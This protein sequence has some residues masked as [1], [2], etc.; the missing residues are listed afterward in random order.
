MK[1]KVL[2]VVCLLMIG[3]FLVQC[4]KYAKLNIGKENYKKI[5][6]TEYFQTGLRYSGEKFGYIYGVEE[7]ANKEGIGDKIVIISTKDKTLYRHGTKVCINGICADNQ[8]IYYAYTEHN[9]KNTSYIARIKNSFREEKKGYRLKGEKNICID[10]IVIV[11]IN[12]YK[13]YMYMFGFDYDENGVYSKMYVY[14][15]KTWDKVKEVRFTDYIIDVTDTDF[16]QNKMYVTGRSMSKVDEEQMIEID[17]KYICEV[18]LEKLS[19]KKIYVGDKG[20]NIV[21]TKDGIFITN[22]DAVLDEGKKIYKIDYNDYEIKCYRFYKT[23]CNKSYFK[24]V[25]EGINN[26]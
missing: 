19:I 22:Y 25:L 1:K 20:N 14:D 24:K 12:I 13:K 18:E 15:T 11:H 21:C 4:N 2:I 6:N 9:G 16:F 8:Y 10:D 26:K 7:T 23:I 3:L 5:Y 17:N